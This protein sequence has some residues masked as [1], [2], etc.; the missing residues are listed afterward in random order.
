MF[1]R[2]RY[3]TGGMIFQFGSFTLAPKFKLH[4]Y[5]H[6]K[7]FHEEKKIILTHIE[8]HVH[9][10]HKHAYIQRIMH[11]Y[12]NKIQTS[13][14]SHPTV[15]TDSQTGANTHLYYFMC[16]VKIFYINISYNSTRSLIPLGKAAAVPV[17]YITTTTV[18]LTHIK[19]PNRSLYIVYVIYNIYIYKYM[20]KC[21]TEETLAQNTTTT[22]TK[23]TERKN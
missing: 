7:L 18:P 20:N 17:Y 22:I 12:K 9:T 15:S 11:S 4:T 16:T 5:K 19:Q 6:T 13:L 23:R 10:T 14:S 21:K 3:S 2:C 8:T 1:C